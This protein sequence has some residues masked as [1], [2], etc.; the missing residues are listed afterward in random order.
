VNADEVMAVPPGPGGHDGALCGARKRRSEGTC[1]Q[2]AG[3]GTDH[4]GDGPCKLHGGATR[5]QRTASAVRQVEAEARRALA[6]L[7]VT[8]PV[9]NP[10]LELQRLAGEIVAFK[11]AL[12]GMV[13]QLSS[14]RYDGPAGE[15]IRGEII[16]YERA[17]DRCTRVLRDI[18][19]LRI[20]ERLVEIQSRVTEH[21]GRLVA[22]VIRAILHDLAL[23]PNQQARVHEVVPRRLRELTEGGP[24]ALR[25]FEEGPRRLTLADFD[26][27]LELLRAERD[28]LPGPG[29]PPVG[30]WAESSGAGGG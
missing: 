17:L 26:R 23:T 27:E 29:F 7:G 5:N 3:W 16:T 22:G 25:K 13:E 8:T 18:A 28:A 10:L 4:V 2:A 1:A 15:Q 14:V 9:T 30:G 20:D 11:D 21:H 6:D 12:R 24:D 19:A